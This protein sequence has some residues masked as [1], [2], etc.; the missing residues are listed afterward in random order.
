[1]EREKFEQAMVEKCMQRAAEIKAENASGYWKKA[2]GHYN[3]S[4]HACFVWLLGPDAESFEEIRDYEDRTVLSCDGPF[5]ARG[6]TENGNP[7]PKGHE[8][9]RIEAYMERTNWNVP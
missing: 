4:K 2:R 6:C 7:V 5:T 9:E 1:V 3:R 8:P